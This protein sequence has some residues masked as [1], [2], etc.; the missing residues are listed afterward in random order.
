MTLDPVIRRRCEDHRSQATT[1]GKDGGEVQVN[2]GPRVRP[3]LKAGGARASSG[4]VWEGPQIELHS[5]AQ[6][7]RELCLRLIARGHE[8][9]L[10]STKISGRA[11][12][13]FPGQSL[14]EERMRRPMERETA[15]TVRH[16]WPPSFAPPAQGHWVMIQPWEFG[17]LPR[18]WIGPMSEWVDEI[19]AYTRFVRDS[20]LTSGVPA[21]RVHVVPLGIDPGRF[22]RGT[23]PFPLKT[24]KPFKF[25][26]FSGSSGLEKS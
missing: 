17:S 12:R 6:V 18:L 14:L 4:I 1:S 23:A 5:F 19:W 15:A 7:N 9:E 16:Q 21:D 3:V 13:R 22:S 11:A 26:H 8:L 25:L 24:E 10:L 20:Y 2:G